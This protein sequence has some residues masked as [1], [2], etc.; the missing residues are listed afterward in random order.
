MSK[1]DYQLSMPVKKRAD[2]WV[3]DQNLK[4]DTPMKRFTIDVPADLHKR[5]K[6]HCAMR[7]ENMADVLRAL[8]VR[9]FP[10]DQA[11]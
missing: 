3:V 11:A 6:T 5:I 7:G 2:Q 1:D 10:D 9:E 8:L 4:I